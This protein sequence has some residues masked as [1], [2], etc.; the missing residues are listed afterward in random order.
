MME[1]EEE[2]EQPCGRSSPCGRELALL[3]DIVKT[4]GQGTFSKREVVRQH[5]RNGLECLRISQVVH[6]THTW[7]VRDT[8]VIRTLHHQH[9][10]QMFRMLQSSEPVG[11]V[12]EHAMAGFHGTIKT[13]LGRAREAQALW[14]IHYH[15]WPDVACHGLRPEN[16]VVSVR[17]QLQL[18]PFG[19]TLRVTITMRRRPFGDSGDEGCQAEPDLPAIGPSDVSSSLSSLKRSHTFSDFSTV[20]K[21]AT[22][23]QRA[24]KKRRKVRRRVRSRPVARLSPIPEESEES[25]REDLE[26]CP[27]PG[28]PPPQAPQGETTT[29]PH[30][31]QLRS[32]GGILRSIGKQLRK[33]CCY[34]CQPEEVAPRPVWNM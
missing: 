15:Q 23:H 18:G 9:I 5:H 30:S 8:V 11:A 19:Q 12:T 14:P 21:P 25:S 28:D 2:R 6:I 26:R 32:W 20:G 16:V 31:L 1:E 3:Q 22:R 17:W 4:L 24:R 10:T 7:V 29:S 13:Q 34:C 33:L 27:C